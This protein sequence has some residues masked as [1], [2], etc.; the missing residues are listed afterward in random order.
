[1]I[2]KPALFRKW[3]VCP[4]CGSKVTIYDNTA[5]C[6]GVWTKCTRGCKA[7]F[8][9]VIKNGEQILKAQ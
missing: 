1:M 4:Y 5:E 2:K 8:E 9:L 7:E 6:S 3:A